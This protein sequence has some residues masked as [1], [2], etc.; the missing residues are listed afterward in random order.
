MPVLYAELYYSGQSMQTN[1]QGS[2]EARS[3][4]DKEMQ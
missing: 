3:L 2:Y 1:M 4:T